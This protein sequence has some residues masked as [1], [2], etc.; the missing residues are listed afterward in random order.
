M[1]QSPAPIP[2]IA[3]AELLSRY[4]HCYGPSTRGD[5]AAWLGV[6]AG[7]TE[8][9]WSLVEEEMTQ[10]DF[11]RKAWI[12]TGDLDALQS[13]PKPE[14]IRLLPPRDPYTQLRD[15]ETIVDRKYHRDV[16]K[17]VGA[18][19]TVLV[20]GEIAGIWRPRKNRRS[21]KMTI[22]TF[23]SLSDQLKSSVETKAERIATL[24]DSSS[25]DVRFEVH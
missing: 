15:R 5:F 20:D 9:W 11:G 2:E 25:A 8:P 4:L 21:L 19:G 18:P 3:R 10:V 13:S 14:G 6:R 1:I 12:L 7:D 17:A 24:R 22:K 23:N 16:W